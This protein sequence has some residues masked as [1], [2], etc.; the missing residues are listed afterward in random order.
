MAMEDRILR[1]K[2][3]CIGRKGEYRDCSREENHAFTFSFSRY[4]KKSALVRKCTINGGMA[5][6]KPVTC[7]ENYGHHDDRWP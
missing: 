7:S 2:N 4:D 3:C 5:G 6:R 1:L